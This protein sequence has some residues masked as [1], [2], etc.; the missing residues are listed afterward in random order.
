[1]CVA[2]LNALKNDLVCL[3]LPVECDGKASCDCAG[4]A[5]TGSFDLCT[6]SGDADLACD[7]PAC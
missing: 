6:G 7:C 1:M 3:P 4:E 2:Y 5:C